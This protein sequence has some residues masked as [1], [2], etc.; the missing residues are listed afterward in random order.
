MVLILS[1]KRFV[2]H[3]YDILE[4]KVIVIPFVSI[5]KHKKALGALSRQEVL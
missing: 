4:N 3:V 2:F 5:L 1:L